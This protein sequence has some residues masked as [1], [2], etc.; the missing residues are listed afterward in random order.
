[1]IVSTQPS[2]SGNNS[3][4]PLRCTT[5][6]PPGIVLFSFSKTKLGEKKI[7]STILYIQD[8]NLFFYFHTQNS[9]VTSGRAN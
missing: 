1:M 7:K 3:N 2:G 4:R 5:F 9:P 6:T 8:K